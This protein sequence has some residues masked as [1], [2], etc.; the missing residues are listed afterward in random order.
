VPGVPP[1]V[2]RVTHAVVVE[3]AADQG[4]RDPA[5]RLDCRGTGEKASGVSDA[6]AMRAARSRPIMVAIAIAAAAVA[7]RRPEPGSELMQCGFRSYV[8]PTQPAH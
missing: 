2:E 8:I 3:Q 5:I 6:P 1:I 4:L 7:K